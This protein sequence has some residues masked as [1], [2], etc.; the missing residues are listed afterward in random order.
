MNNDDGT[1]RITFSWA[2]PI[3]LP[4]DVIRIETDTVRIA[5]GPSDDGKIDIGL[6]V[7]LPPPM[8]AVRVTLSPDQIAGLHRGLDSLLAL[9]AAQVAALAHHIHNPDVGDETP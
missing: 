6:L 2:E 8:G 3:D 5:L 4:D 9:D 7:Q 1:E